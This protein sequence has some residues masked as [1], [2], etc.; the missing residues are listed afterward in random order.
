MH[1]TTLE[2]YKMHITNLP[3]CQIITMRR[4]AI[5]KETLVGVTDPASLWFLVGM[6]VRGSSRV[7][8]MEG[9]YAS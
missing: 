8:Y 5:V 6:I 4:N 7:R 1:A 2:L 3:S 9:W